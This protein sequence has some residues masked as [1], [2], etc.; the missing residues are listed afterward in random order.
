M[1]VSPPGYVLLEADYKQA[2]FRYWGAYS[3]DPLLKADIEAGVDIHSEMAIKYLDAKRGEVSEWD[4]FIAKMTVFGIMYGRGPQS[5]ADEY[6]IGMD[7]AQAIITDF[8]NQ[9]PTAA[10]WL[11]KVKQFA[12][13]K[14]YVQNWFGRRR[15]LEVLRGHDLSIQGRHDEIV[16]MALR[17][18]MNAPIQGGAHDHLSYT[19]L[20]VD[21]VITEAG[22]DCHTILDIHDALVFEVNEKDLVKSAEIIKYEMERPVVWNGREFPL[23]M[24]V[25]LSK[26]TRWSQMEKYKVEH[27]LEESR[28]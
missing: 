23:R 6:E 7:Q 14:G 27:A 20:R 5:I 8:L 28:T 10:D 22:L 26:G 16:A 21:K 18:S 4:R 1:Y 9:Y 13:E 19:G 3:K 17:Q 11:D 15:H 2:E 24:D 25:D 12:C